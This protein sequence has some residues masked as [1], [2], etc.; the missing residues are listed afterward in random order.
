MILTNDPSPPPA[1]TRRIHVLEVIGN[2]IV[3]GMENWVERLVERLPRARFEI[4]AVAPFESPFTDRLRSHDIEV[5][6]VP[7][8]DDPPWSSVQTVMSMV[9]AGGIDVLHAHLP[10]AHLL[11]GLVGRLT[12][13]PV[14]ATLH[15]RQMTMLDLEIHRAAGSHLSVVCRQSYFHALAIGVNAGRLSCDPNGVDTNVFAPRPGGAA[16]FREKLGIAADAPLAA[17][18][19]RLA[20]EKGPEV[21]IRAAMAL[22]RGRPEAHCVLIGEGPMYFP[23]SAMIEQHGLQQ[24]VTLAGAWQNMPAV[25]N[26]LDLV[27]STSHSEAMPLAVMEAMASGIPVVA[28]RVGGVP[29]MVEHG[30]TGWL[31]APGDFEDVAARSAGI[32]GNPAERQ[33][34]ADRARAR[35]V[36][37]MSLDDAVLRVVQLLG[38]L[39][40]GPSDPQGREAPVVRAVVGGAG[41]TS[42]RAG[43]SNAPGREPGR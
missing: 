9:V 21:F 34:M 38:R 43:S 39:G 23:L 6:V 8:P 37:R 28:T 14:V 11:A 7:M 4:T 17:F 15:G 25:F 19:G 2:A 24:R 5:F 32:L 18:V 13:R 40:A 12:G 22:L 29:E 1:S 31:V 42:R 26:E 20:A 35:A 30:R 33:K 16:G 10:N 41:G 36:E 3:G 27:V